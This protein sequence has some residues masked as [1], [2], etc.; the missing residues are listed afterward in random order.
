[1]DLEKKQTQCKRVLKAFRE[2][3][4]YDRNGGWLN[5]INLGSLFIM[6]PHAIMFELER[7][8]YHFEKRRVA[9]HTYME[10]RL[11]DEPRQTNIFEE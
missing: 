8:G 4:E 3:I 2:A 9:G 5:C 7:D 6:Q 11:I 1:M 10:Y